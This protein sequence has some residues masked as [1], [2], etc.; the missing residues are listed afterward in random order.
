MTGGCVARMVPSSGIVTL[1]SASSSSRNASKSSSARSISSISSTAG[2]G[3]GC[4][5]ARSSGPADQV[6]RPE[7]V[8]L[9]QLLAARVGEPDAQQLAR[10][11]PLVQRLGG[12][13]PLVALQADQRGVE[14][15]GERLG[16][17]GLADAG[18]ALEQQ[19]LGQASAEEHRRRQALVDE[20]VDAGEPLCQRLDVGHEV[21]ELARRLAGHRH[22]VLLCVH[23]ARDRARDRHLGHLAGA[24]V[25]QPPDALVAVQLGQRAEGAVGEG[26]RVPAAVLV[27]AHG[28]RRVAAAGEQRPHGLLRHA[29]LVAEHQHQHVAAQ[30]DGAQRRGD[31]RGAAVAV[32][33]VDDHVDAARGRRPR[34]RRRPRRPARRRP[35]RR[36][37]PRA[38]STT[39]PSSV[40]SP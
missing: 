35:G 11:V 16:R 30:V 26:D 13:D 4:S 19:R 22:V 8:L 17:L 38:T 39:W 34:A 25:E 37:T 2:R 5:S 14:H 31:R 40:P 7:Q 33:V 32:V 12:V 6:V 20:V 23:V 1:A 29:R 9:A 10:V 36:S 18:L 24:L 28:E 15:R 21:C 3:P 27:A